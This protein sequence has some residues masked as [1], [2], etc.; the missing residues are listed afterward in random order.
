MVQL[1]KENIPYMAELKFT[2]ALFRTLA[3]F[4]MIE[5]DGWLPGLWKNG[6]F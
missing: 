4:V 1:T 6:P 5:E 3:V 2:D